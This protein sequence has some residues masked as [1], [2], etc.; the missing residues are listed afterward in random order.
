MKY[1][2]VYTL[3][4]ATKQTGKAMLLSSLEGKPYYKGIV[5]I[6]FCKVINLSKNISKSTLHNYVGKSGFASVEEWLDKLKRTQEI[7]YLYYVLKPR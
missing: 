1:G 5:G 2:E 3:R 7:Y 4:P 6:H